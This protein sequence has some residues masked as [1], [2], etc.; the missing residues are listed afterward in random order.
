MADDRIARYLPV[1]L[2]IAS[3][4]AASVN[5]LPRGT[6]EY[7]LYLI[8]DPKLTLDTL[9][10]EVFRSVY[11]AM[12]MIHCRLFAI[13][14]SMPWC[15]LLNDPLANLKEFVNQ[16]RM[17]AGLDHVCYKLYRLANVDRTMTIYYAFG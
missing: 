7:L 14:L 9:M 10:H 12:G 17:P 8:G 5:A 3:D 15:L 4:Q 1:L 2:K 6:W 11:I 16:D 13:A